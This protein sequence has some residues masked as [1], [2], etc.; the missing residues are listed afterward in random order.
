[1]ER[2]SLELPSMKYYRIPVARFADGRTAEC[3]PRTA[4]EHFK[5]RRR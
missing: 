2:P 4:A 5:E 3:L 1:M